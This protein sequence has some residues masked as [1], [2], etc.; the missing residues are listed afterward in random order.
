M[1]LL[2]KKYSTEDLRSFHREFQK[3]AGEGEMNVDNFERFLVE[4][5][6][7]FS[8]QFSGNLDCTLSTLS[9]WQRFDE[10]E[11]NSVDFSEFVS[12]YPSM[13]RVLLRSSVRHSGA[14]EFFDAFAVEGKFTRE[15]ILRAVARYGLDPYP[16]ADVEKLMGQIAPH[17]QFGDQEDIEF[18]ANSED[19]SSV[20]CCRGSSVFQQ[21][22][23]GSE[24]SSTETSTDKCAWVQVP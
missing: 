5:T 11:N 18:W 8:Y 17:K 19:Y 10:D 1:H 13:V 21:D 2:P 4:K 22:F 3:Y 24:L 20:S 15:S 6:A 12:R 7:N 16:E 9:W 14:H 23:Y